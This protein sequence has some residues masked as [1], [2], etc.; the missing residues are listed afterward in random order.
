MDTVRVTHSSAR[1]TPHDRDYSIIGFI[2]GFLVM[3]VGIMT[4]V[5]WIAAV[6]FV[7]MVVSFLFLNSMVWNKYFQNTSIRKMLQDRGI[8]PSWIDRKLDS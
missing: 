3:L 5:T 7:P 2:G 4:G 6:G 8:R 1:I